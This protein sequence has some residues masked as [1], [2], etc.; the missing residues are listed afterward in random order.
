MVVSGLARRPTMGGGSPSWKGKCAN[1]AAHL[2]TEL[3]VVFPQLTALR[4]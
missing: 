1:F 4:Q 2:L 3:R